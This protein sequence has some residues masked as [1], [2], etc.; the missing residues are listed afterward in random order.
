MH[1]YVVLYVHDTVNSLCARAVARAWVEPT[2]SRA[3]GT[4]SHDLMAQ[5]YGDAFRYLT[6]RRWFDP[7]TVQL[8]QTEF[9]QLTFS[10]NP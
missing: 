4:K 9:R 8:P 2:K 7:S 1:L 3:R 10:Q 6:T 5:A